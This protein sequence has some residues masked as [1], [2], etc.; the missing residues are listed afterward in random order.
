MSFHALTRSDITSLFKGIGKK[1]AWEAVIPYQDRVKQIQELSTNAALHF[2]D[3]SIDWIFIDALHTK[4]GLYSDLTSWWNKVRPGGLISGDDYGDM[5]DTRLIKASR[6]AKQFGGVAKDSENKW[7]VI[8][9]LQK[10][11]VEKNVILH[12]T[13]NHDCYEYPA[14]YFMK[15]Y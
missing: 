2:E 10:F 5:D 15:P 8:S 6:W 9:A 4:Q 13:W 3:N 14:W 12:V 1:K 7:G 11:T